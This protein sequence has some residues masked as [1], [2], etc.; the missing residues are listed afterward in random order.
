MHVHFA[1][2]EL[3]ALDRLG[4]EALSLPMFSDERPLAGVLGLVDWRVC[5]LLSRLLGQGRITGEESEQVLLPGRPKFPID[6]VFVF[7]LGA[8]S[9]LD[10]ARV[11]SCIGRMF[12]AFAQARVRSAALVLPGRPQGYIDPASAIEA[13]VGATS[14]LDAHDEVVVLELPEAQREMEAVLERERRRARA[15]VG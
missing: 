5:G 6:K 9:E 10:L 14:A 3:G 2:P 8:A 11:R 13:L 12:A 1:S 4:V 15:R 7:G